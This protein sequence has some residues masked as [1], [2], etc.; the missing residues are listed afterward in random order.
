M[1]I[2]S[3]K[4]A[5]LRCGHDGAAKEECVELG[6][7]SSSERREIPARMDAHMH[8][9]ITTTS[10]AEKGSGS[11]W[12]PNRGLKIPYQ[13]GGGTLSVGDRPPA[14]FGRSRPRYSNTQNTQIPWPC[15]CLSPNCLLTRQSTHSSR[16][17][18]CFDQKGPVHRWVKPPGDEGANRERHPRPLQLKGAGSSSAAPGPARARCG[19][20]EEASRHGA[21]A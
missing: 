10:T 7:D 5:R 1:Y 12:K 14:R 17:E 18:P 8:T 9:Q 13:M 20:C 11:T 19:L 16:G 21:G 15:R 4:W 2:K 6:L 3:C